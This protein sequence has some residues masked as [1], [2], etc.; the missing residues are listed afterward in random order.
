M[1]E[2]KDIS[3]RLLMAL[4]PDEFPKEA[5][6]IQE[7]LEAC[8]ECKAELETLGRI[9]E[10]LRAHRNELA[11]ATDPCPP[12]EM[13]V[14]VALGEPAEAS[15][16]SH[17]ELCRECSQYVEI[18]RALA[19]DEPGEGQAASDDRQRQFIRLLVNREYGAGPAAEESRQRSLAEFFRGLFRLPAVAVAAAVAV[20]VAIWLQ[21]PSQQ[22]LRPVFSDAVRFGSEMYTPEFRF[23]PKAIPIKKRS[24]AVLIFSAGKESPR[25][26][27]LQAFYGQLDIPER[28]RDSYEFIKP[29]KVKEALNTAHEERNLDAWAKVIFAK[30]PADV[31]LAF[32]VSRSGR[33]YSLKAMLYNRGQTTAVGTAAQAGLTADSVPSRIGSMAMELLAQSAAGKAKEASHR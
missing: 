30:L 23:I 13:L 8:S 9:A 5:R 26:E 12:A 18:V 32:L 14:A 7:H 22:V 24:V 6:E 3:E 16:V 2:C 19:A 29:G 17:V 25:P 20:A 33:N 1:S 11:G 31:F 10:F 28:L 27:D 15:T 4:Y 21:I